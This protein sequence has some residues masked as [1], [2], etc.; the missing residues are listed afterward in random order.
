[1][2]LSVSWITPAVRGVAKGL[3]NAQDFSFRLDNF[4]QQDLFFRLIRFESLSSEIGRLFYLS[5]LFSL[6]VPFR[7]LP[8]RREALSDI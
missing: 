4:T 5:Y 8:I 2:N 3:A 6:A 1:M 7:W